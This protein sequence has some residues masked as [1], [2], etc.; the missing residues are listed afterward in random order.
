MPEP[1][2]RQKRAE[3]LEGFL[4]RPQLYITPALR[5]ALEAQARVNLADAIAVLRGAG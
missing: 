5:E 3:V 4:G 2:F 1:L